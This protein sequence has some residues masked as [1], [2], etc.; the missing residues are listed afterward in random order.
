[1]WIV[2]KEPRPNSPYIKLF[3][4]DFL[5]PKSFFV[6][7]IACALLSL[8]INHLQNPILRYSN[9]SL[10]DKWSLCLGGINVNLCKYLLSLKVAFCA[11]SDSVFCAVLRDPP[12]VKTMPRQQNFVTASPSY[13]TSKSLGRELYRKSLFSSY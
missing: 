11:W 9:L 2:F 3:C 1:M 12:L 7:K 10:S 4:V 8:F 5:I 13:K 6:C